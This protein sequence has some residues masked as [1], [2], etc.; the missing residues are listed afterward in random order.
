MLITSS[1]FDYVPLGIE[2]SNY[3]RPALR[4]PDQREDRSL[5]LNDL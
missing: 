4:A 3:L 1:T 2:L 5:P